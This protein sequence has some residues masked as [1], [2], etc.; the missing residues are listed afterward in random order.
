MA[1]QQQQQ[2]V[3]LVLRLRRVRRLLRGLGPPLM[4]SWRS[5]TG[6][7]TQGCGRKGRRPSVCWDTKLKFSSFV[8]VCVW[9]GGMLRDRQRRAGGCHR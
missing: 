4:R 3:V 9:G 8:C 2:V 1:V 5:S 7:W 6:E